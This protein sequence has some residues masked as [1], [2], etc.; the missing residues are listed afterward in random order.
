MNG[1]LD[2]LRVSAALTRPAMARAAAAPPEIPAQ[3]GIAPAHSP[4]APAALHHVSPVSSA[5]TAMPQA[6]HAAADATRQPP[7]RK[8]AIASSLQPF[9]SEIGNPAGT[10]LPAAEIACALL[11]TSLAWGAVLAA[12]A[13]PGVQ[14][15]GS[16]WLLPLGVA[17]GLAAL[18][19]AGLAVRRWRKGLAALKT[20]EE[21]A[22]RKGVTDP[23]TRLANRAGYRIHVEDALTAREDGQPIGVVYIDLDRFKEVNDT[24]GH[25]MGDKLLCAVTARLAE[26]AAGR[27]IGARLGGD[28]FALVVI[29]CADA[30]EIVG[31]GEEISKKLGL[32]FGIDGVELGIGGSVGVAIAPADGVDYSELV[33]RADI[34][35]YRAKGAG[36]GNCMRFDPEMEDGARK[37]KKMEDQLRRAIER[38]EMEMVYQPVFASDGETIRGVEAL[39][40][41]D[42]PVFGQV[43]PGEFIPL[44]EETGLIGEIGA[45]TFK[46]ALDHAK[47]WPD[48]DI[49]INVS[50]AQFRAKGLAQSIIDLVAASGIAAK[51]IEVEVTEGVLIRDADRAA[52]TIARIRGAGMRVALDDFGTGFSSLSYLRRFQFDKLKIDQVFVKT[53]SSDRGGGSGSAAI[54]HNVVALGRSL[55][56]TVQAEGVETLEHHIFL[57]AAG[58]HCLQGFYFARPMPK[59]EFDAFLGKRRGF[60]VDARRFA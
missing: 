54:I 5:A 24:Y 4:L 11:S 42:S 17:G 49:A 43:S 53:L 35:M 1:P 60:I 16:E 55:G 18:G 15:Y 47:D 29:G 34:A 28:E 26:I 9:S 19:Q 52:A 20:V 21:N 22:R 27:A 46:V 37:R 41:W 32:P 45:W 48:I 39:V 13:I 2:R 31:L 25:E 56:L 6:E 38:G 30:D 36:R 50:P 57:R 3:I 58:C 23:L 33:R 59:P 40:R 10:L 44:A 51:R 14:A 12:G 8:P 7:A